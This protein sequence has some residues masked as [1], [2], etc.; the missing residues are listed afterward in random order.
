[1]ALSRSNRYLWASVQA[2]QNGPYAGYISAFLLD[3]DGSII[4]RMFTTPVS[5]SGGG[6]NTIS[7]AP[8][9]DEWAALTDDETGHVQMWRMRGAKATD[10]GA[11]YNAVEAVARVEITDGGCCSNAIWYN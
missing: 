7:P 6:P 10:N 3:D 4:K 11:E 2:N 8:W 1:M 5:T 9:D